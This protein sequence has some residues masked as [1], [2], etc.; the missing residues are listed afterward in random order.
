MSNLGPF[1]IGLAAFL[2]S[3]DAL[4]RQPLTGQL[5]PT[6]I[7]LLE[8][9][10]GL[11]ILLPLLARRR[12]ELRNLSGRDWLAVLAI[13]VG[14]S[15]L[16]TILFTSAF[17]YVGPSVAILLQK[18]QPLVAILLAVSLLGERLR[19]RFWL[20]SAV[21]VAAAYVI[22]FPDLKITW[23]LY[24]NGT[25]GVLYALGAAFLWG[26]STVFGRYAVQKVS[27]PT[28]SAL[29]FAVAAVTIA[30]MMTAQGTLGSLANLPGT[31]FDR[32]L[33]IV[34]ISGTT[35]ILLYYKGLKT[36]R[37][38]VSTIVELIFPFSAVV[39]N[40]IFLGDKLIWQQIVAGLV[41]LY[42]I[43]RV[44]RFNREPVR[45]TQGELA[46]VATPNVDR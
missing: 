29:R 8:H 13:G 40:W 24:D 34:L 7:V 37:A 26:A 11:G 30:V 33:A 43:V 42:A 20:W 21:A 44:Q 41:L 31:A 9:L 17:R 22:S 14:G 46:P 2:W 3:T 16:A 28:M 1:F 10:L 12:V 25:R 18:I 23:S 36:T 38:S 19:A 4:F 15:A 27:Y 5:S 32:L 39:L 45:S 35:A 6:S